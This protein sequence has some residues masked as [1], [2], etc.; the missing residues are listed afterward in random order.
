VVDLHFQRVQGGTTAAKYIRSAR[1]YRRR[2]VRIDGRSRAFQAIKLK[3]QQYT[4]AIGHAAKE[5]LT[6]ARIVELA[7]LEVL[8]S[9]LRAAGLRGEA[10]NFDLFQLARFTNTANRLRQALGLNT[11]PEPELPTLDQLLAGEE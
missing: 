5:P 4:R 7:E 3:V 2:I 9:E 10:N 11:T 6:R 8:T 1:T